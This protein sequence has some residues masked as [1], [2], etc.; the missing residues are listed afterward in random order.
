MLRAKGYEP[1]WKDWDG[2]FLEQA[3]GPVHGV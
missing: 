2:A 1:V 3:D